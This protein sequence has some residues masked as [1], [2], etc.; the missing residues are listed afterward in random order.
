MAQIPN[1]PLGRIF[2]EG[3]LSQTFR[4]IRGFLDRLLAVPYLWGDRQTVTF[5]SATTIPVRHGLGR[6]P[7]GY[8]VEGLSADARVFDGT[9]PS[10]P[11]PSSTHIYLAAS[12]AVTAKLRIF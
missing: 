2:E 11:L 3:P 8:V 4:E 1:T 5:P 7:V 12:A 10:S 6:P 9:I